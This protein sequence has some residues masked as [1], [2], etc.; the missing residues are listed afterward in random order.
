MQLSARENNYNNVSLYNKV[1]QFRYCHGLNSFVSAATS[2]FV[3]I[4][5]HSADVRTG[6]VLYR[7]LVVDCFNRVLVFVNRHT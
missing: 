1:N 6:Y 3:A 5:S 2:C 4:Q 7:A